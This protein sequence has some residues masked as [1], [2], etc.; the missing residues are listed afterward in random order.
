VN[1]LSYSAKP[2]NFPASWCSNGYVLF[3]EQTGDRKYKLIFPDGAKAVRLYTGNSSE[4]GVLN[5]SGY[6]DYRATEFNN[7]EREFNIT[8]S[9]KG[10]Y[11]EVGIRVPE[12]ATINY[13]IFNITGFA[14]SGDWYNELAE[15]IDGH[16]IGRENSISVDSNNKPH[17]SHYDSTSDDLRY[18]DKSSGSWSCEIVDSNGNVGSFT[19][20]DIDSNDIPHISYYYSSLNYLKYANKTGDSWSC[21]TASTVGGRY[22]SISLDSND[23]PHISH[24]DP[25]NKD[26]EY[27]NH[28]GL[29][30]SCENVDTSGDMGKYTSIGL[31]S[32]NKPHISYYNGD[33]YDL[34]YANKTGDS[35]SCETADSS[36]TVGLYTS[37]AIDTNDKPHIAHYDFSS[38]SVRYCN[39]TVSW[40]CEEV[41]NIKPEDVSLDL[42]SNNVPHIAYIKSVADGAYQYLRYCDKSSGSWSC[43]N[44]D[45][46]HYASAWVS[47]KIDSNDIPHISYW[48]LT[49][50]DLRYA[51]KRTGNATNL[52]IILNGTAIFDMNGSFTT[53]NQTIDFTSTFQN[54]IENQKGDS[55]G[56]VTCTLNF[57]SDSSG[58][59]E[60]HDFLLN[61]TSDVSAAFN[62]FAWWDQ[63]NN[64][65][66]GQLYNYS[67]RYK[68]SAYVPFTDLNISG[69]YINSSAT[70][71]KLD[72][73]TK[74]VQ[75]QGSKKYCPIDPPE[76]ILSGGGGTWT[77]HTVWDNEMGTG[78]P[79]NQSNGTFTD[80]GGDEVYKYVNITSYLSD[81]SDSSK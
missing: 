45:T 36:A 14:T 65:F 51:S 44:I 48:D 34:K 62:I 56:F 75:S 70:E 59:I 66:E 53:N 22:T 41:D 31:D 28:T 37:I 21:E 30:W 38:S 39:K 42:D 7:S 2:I 26:L 63:S 60:V 10:S 55:D 13:A 73:N 43:E 52:T 5:S 8:F 68:T 11:T 49:G 47:L 79:I 19:S 23:K 54:C 3:S 32:N 77:N 9:S 16:S 27:C 58:M 81:G 12:N 80:D 67:I 20:I 18:C 17:I 46:L 40:S 1:D 78:Y 4:A 76:T 50:S 57:S 69:I 72:G 24:Y 71:C 64:I 35:W 6:I 61:F 25:N 33:V 29:T 15:N 74:S